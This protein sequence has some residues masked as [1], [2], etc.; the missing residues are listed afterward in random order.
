MKL[1]LIGLGSMGS[2]MLPHLLKA[3]HAVSVWNRS[4]VALPD[5][6]AKLASPAAAFEGDAVITMLAND[7]AVRSVIID[8][9]ALASARHGCVHVVMA[10]I[11]LALVDE[12]QA[13]HAAAGVAYVAAPVFGVPAVAAQAELNILAA[14][15]AQAVATVQPLF[16]VLGRKTWH[17][18]SDPK[19]ANVAKLAGNM[20]ITLAIEAMGEAVALTE[21]YGLDGA[22]FLDVVTNTLFASPSYKRYGANIATRIYE[23]GF[24]LSLG[25]K[26]VNLALAAAK[27]RGVELPAARIVRAAMTEAVD[28]GLGNKDWSVFA[29]R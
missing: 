9:K 14:G 23:P 27:H 4:P 5:G 12:L 22:D 8:S 2:A 13:L 16:D 3:G 6:V 1:A 7:D 20:M 17:L 10:T 28:Q 21:S 24:K 25:L 26:D 19:R 15:D 29:R 18:G 11:S